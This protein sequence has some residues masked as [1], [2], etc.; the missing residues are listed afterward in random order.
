[1][2]NFRRKRQERKGIEYDTTPR[3][4]NAN[5]IER[6]APH[7]SRKKPLKFRL[8]K[9]TR[10][11]EREQREFDNWKASWVRNIVRPICVKRWDEHH[12][13]TLSKLH[14]RR[15]ELEEEQAK[16]LPVS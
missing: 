4:K 7:P 2:A 12:T 6:P 8:A 11:I 14:R 9:L 13:R 3:K 1:M 5:E 15:K 10:M 16:R